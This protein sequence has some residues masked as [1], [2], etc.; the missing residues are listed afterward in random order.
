MASIDP[1]TADIEHSLGSAVVHV[2]TQSSSK[3]CEIAVLE[4]EDGRKLFVKYANTKARSWFDAEARSL[5]W[6][7][8][9]NAVRVPMVYGVSTSDSK[10]PWLAMSYEPEAEATPNAAHTLGTQLA[11]LHRSGAEQFGFDNPGY[12]ATIPQDNTLTATWPE[13]YGTRRVEPLARQA[14]DAD[15]LPRSTTAQLGKLL[16]RLGD[17][18]G[19]PEPPARLH[20]DLWGGNWHVTTNDTPIIFDPASYGGHREIDL[21][22]MRIFGGFSNEC[23]HAYETVYP[24]TNGAEDRVLL[25]QI[26][27]LLVHV[28]LFG[29]AYTDQ[30]LRAI[31]RY[32]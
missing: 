6:L 15:L 32:V 2:E 27:P 29:E 21:A 4:L 17:L 20:G 23:F 13:F 19:D 24:L 16:N 1:V 11:A 28:L 14:I 18:C 12:I 25:Y 9:P 10:N 3:F 22:M 26:Y 5:R 30:T 31:S 7:A 8:E